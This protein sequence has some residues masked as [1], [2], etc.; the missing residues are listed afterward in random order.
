MEV[1]AVV[2]H[3]CSKWAPVFSRCHLAALWEAACTSEAE[4]HPSLSF[5]QAHSCAESSTIHSSS[6][7]RRE[8]KLVFKS[9][10]RKRRRMQTSL[11]MLSSKDSSR[12]TQMASKR[13]KK[14]LRPN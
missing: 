14:T 10:R 6:S 5:K 11:Q 3:E 8:K 13:R 12:G 2:V 9:K 4:A 1:E 7:D